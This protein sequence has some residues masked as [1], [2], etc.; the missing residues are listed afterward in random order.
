MKDVE[1]KEN[2]LVKYD[3]LGIGHLSNA[4]GAYTM[5]LANT[6]ANGIDFWRDA[7]AYMDKGASSI[8]PHNEMLNTFVERYKQLLGGSGSVIQNKLSQSV[9]LVKKDQLDDTS[10]SKLRKMYRNFL[11]I[12]LPTLGAMYDSEVH[13][14]IKYKGDPAIVATINKVE[15]ALFNDL[16]SGDY[17]LLIP[18][19]SLSYKRVTRMIDTMFYNVNS[20]HPFNFFTIN[21]KNKKKGPAY[22]ARPLTPNIMLYLQRTKEDSTTRLISV[23]RDGTPVDLWREGTNPFG[24]L[25]IVNYITSLRKDKGVLSGNA[26]DEAETQRVMKLLNVRSPITYKDVASLNEIIKNINGEGDE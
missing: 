3:L 12:G 5:E 7:F 2:F 24:D 13:S 14:I 23:V 6:Y 8:S 19:V 21:A 9:I 16:Y 25:F 15:E 10:M 26:L 20:R 4:N 11:L 18:F 1:L 17:Y 22:I